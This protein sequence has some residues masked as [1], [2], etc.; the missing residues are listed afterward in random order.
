[1]PT[2]ETKR[3]ILRPLSVSDQDDM[4]DT[5]MSD[6]DVMYWLP[7]S[8]ETSTPEGQHEVA[9]RYIADFIAPWETLGFGVWALCMKDRDQG[10]PGAFIG[11]CGFFPGQIKGAGPEIAY[12]VGK[13]MWGKGL[14]TEALTACLD[15]IF[16][17][18]DVSRVYA[19]TD[20]GNTASRRVMEKLG[21]RHET[22]VDLYQ[23][24]AKGEGLLPFYT[25]ERETYLKRGA[26][27]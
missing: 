25:I 4:V 20:T 8:D 26:K 1:M 7:G 27:I 2:L 9:S 17:R 18:P 11:Y 22:D 19:V 21:M 3:L 6:T 10:T 24:V 15:W 14:V 16:T 13:S 23:S 5:I 12:A